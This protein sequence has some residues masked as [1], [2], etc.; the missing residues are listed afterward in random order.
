MTLAT[1]VA[2]QIGNLFAQRTEST[3]VWRMRWGGNRFVWVGIVTEL[4]LLTL[5][6]YVPILQR[7][8]DTA[9]FPL[10]HWLFV[11]AWTPVLLVAD[12][13]RKALVRRRAHRTGDGRVRA[14][15]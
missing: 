4:V 9:P 14:S 11:L 12:E 2:T 10:S 3:S 8:F 1:V 13:G 5:L 6:L 15:A 7:L